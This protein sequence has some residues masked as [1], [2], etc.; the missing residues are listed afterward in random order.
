MLLFCEGVAE[1]FRALLPFQKSERQQAP[2]AFAALAAGDRLAVIG[3]HGEAAITVD[4]KPGAAGR[5][6]QPAEDIPAPA[7]RFCRPRMK[8]IP[9]GGYF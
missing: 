4:A 9:I 7:R 6:I 2:G 1:L 8:F 3:D 5:Q